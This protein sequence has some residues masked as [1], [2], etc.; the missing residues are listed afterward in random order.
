MNAD[1]Q[2]RFDLTNALH[3]GRQPSLASLPAALPASAGW[4]L[5]RVKVLRWAEVS[6]QQ[7]EKHGKSNRLLQHRKLGIGLHQALSHSVAGLGHQDDLDLG[8]CGQGSLRQLAAVHARHGDIGEKQADFGRM[9][10]EI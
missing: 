6:A 10:L 1:E 8:C 2:P 7:L 5:T 9:P 4:R 3:Y